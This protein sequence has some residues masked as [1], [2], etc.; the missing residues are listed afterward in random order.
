MEIE[1]L[2]TDVKWNIL[3]AL[4]KEPKSPLQISEELNTTISNISQQIKLLEMA[5]LVQKR[6][7]SNRDKGK[8]RTLFSIADDFSFLV[9]LTNTTASKRFFKITDYHKLILRIWFLDDLELHYYLQ[10]FYWEIES[11]LSEIKGIAITPGLE[12]QVILLSDNS[13]K[14]KKF[15]GKK[16]IRSSD[17]GKKVFH[18]Q[19]FSQEDL[20]KRSS[21][22]KDYYIIYDPENILRRIKKI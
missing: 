10:K 22:L 1:S 12:V 5:G 19:A 11:E 20:E 13:M 17:G 8:P 3:E 14:I 15:L 16:E 18:C 21:F 4:S 2:F 9:L 7:I 6:K